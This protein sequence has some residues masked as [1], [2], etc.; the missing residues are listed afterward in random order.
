MTDCG[1]HWVRRRPRRL[2]GVLGAA[3]V[4]LLLVP[5]ALGAQPEAA[6]TESVRGL[7][8]QARALASRNEA[9]AAA[10]ALGRAVALAPNSEDVLNAYARFSLARGNPI[11]ATLALEPLAR[12]HPGE[13]E[14]AYLLGVARMQVGEMAEAAEA[15]FDAAALDRNRALTHIAL[16]LALNRVDR[17]DEAREA[18]ATALRLEPDNVEALA[19]MSETTEGLGMLAE[20][21]ALAER[22]L[23]V[24]P[25]HPTALVTI[26]TARLKQGRFE[27]AREALARAVAAEPDSIKGHYQ[28]SLALARLGDREGAERHLRLSREAQAAI[29]EH[30]ERL[31]AQ[32]PLGSRTEP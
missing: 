15:L 29:E 28:F 7:L 9:D 24:N 30:I 4:P 21:T 6:A 12:M 31:R 23:A 16:G 32:P 19:A 2:S 5:T 13:A 1:T 3:L 10:E 20:A 22:A 25:D 11:Q 18:L 14:Y 27:E 17:F 26:G 8:D